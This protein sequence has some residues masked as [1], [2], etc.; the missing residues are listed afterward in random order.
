MK[1]KD[2]NLVNCF[3]KLLAMSFRAAPCLFITAVSFTIV[4]GVTFGMLTMFQQR[5]F[6]DAALLMTGDMK[7][8]AIILSLAGFIL[9]LACYYIA[10]SLGDIIPFAWMEKV[11]GKLSGILHRKLS[12]IAPVFYEDTNKLDDINKAEQGKNNAVRFVFS[13]LIIFSF[14]IPYFLF[15]SAYLFTLKPILALAVIFVFTPT[16]ASQI[17]RAKVFSKMEDK[18]A[19]VRREYEYYEKCLVGREYYKET[20]L[21]GS[22]GYFKKRYVASLKLLN[23]IS[24]R[25]TVKANLAELSM[26]LLAAAGYLGILYL[27][28]DSLINMEI[29]VGAFVAVFTSIGNLFAVM[30]DAVCTIFGNVSKDWGTIQNYLSFLRMEERKGK[31]VELPQALDIEL[32]N[33]TFAYPQSNRNAISQV[34]FTIRDKETVA[35]VGENGSGKTTLIRLL[36]GL[37]APDEGSV[38]YGNM[39]CSDISMKSLFHNTSAVFQNYQKYQLTLKENITISNTESD[40][41]DNQLSAICKAVGIDENNQNVYPDH[42]DTMLSREFDGVDLSGGQWQRVAIARG[43]FRE[44]KIIVLDEPTAA[45]DPIEE[46][47]LYRQFADIAK[48]NT[49]II[50]TH[51]LGSIKFVNRIIVMKEGRVVE[52]GSHEELIARQGEY[53]RMFHS[54]QKWYEG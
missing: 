25:A 14:H 13:F 23:K 19:P 42:L 53:A 16:M 24:F 50:V 38:L 28:F 31:D 26:K 21:L 30:E 29:T 45:I 22:A 46:T 2:N 37:Y 32:R 27:L 52:I 49:A 5:F 11:Q 51:R 10:H 17:L 7:F 8:L 33:V 34:H 6:D 12:R 40:T 44:H 41:D 36:T 54:Q 43:L 3:F 9:I 20:R 48:N 35:I 18:S 15:M 47:K 39:D 4:E 1:N